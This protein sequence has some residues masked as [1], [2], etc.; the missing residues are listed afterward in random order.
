MLEQGIKDMR[1]HFVRTVANKHLIASHIIEIGY[2]FTH[3]IR[4]RVWIQAQT[5]G[6]LGLQ[7]CQDLGA[8]AVGIFIGVELDQIADLGLLTRNIRGEL[9]H[10]AAPELAQD[11]PFKRYSAERAWACKPSP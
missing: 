8:G 9:M 6:H 5:I 7:G 11:Q 1:Q 2:R 3:P 10:D 4:S